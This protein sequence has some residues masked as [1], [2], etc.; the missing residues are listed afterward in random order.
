MLSNSTE[1]FNLKPTK[2]N[3]GDQ[4]PGKK[5]M[6]KANT[7]TDIFTATETQWD[8]LIDNL[9]NMEK[10]KPEE[11]RKQLAAVLFQKVMGKQ[12]LGSLHLK[13]PNNLNLSQNSDI[14]SSTSSSDPQP[15]RGRSLSK[16]EEKQVNSE[17]VSPSTPQ[18]SPKESNNK[19][20]QQVYILNPTEMLTP[21]IGLATKK[22]KAA[23]YPLSARSHE[24]LFR[25]KISISGDNIVMNPL[26]HTNSKNPPKPVE[27][28]YDST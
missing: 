25:T 11:N 14:T 26:L 7:T 5:H 10:G 15:P 17:K 22:V 19:P 2:L 18:K 24:R 13:P 3:F 12:K 23:H 27:I 4:S 16:K 8:E 28:D 21:P 1:A 6:R 9:N 20:N